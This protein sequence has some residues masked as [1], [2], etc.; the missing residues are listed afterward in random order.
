M[1]HKF[2]LRL[3]FIGAVLL[4]GT[5]IQLAKEHRPSILRP[6]LRLCAYVTNAG[7]GTVSVV[8][9]VRL[10]VTS[11]LP[12]GPSP[13]GI[14]A[15]PTRKEIWGVSTEGG[16]AWV[17]DAVRDQV[18]ARIPVGAAPFA[19][20]FSPEGNFAYVA[21]SGSAT[22]IAIDCRTRQVAG[23]A[24]TGRR[25][26]LARVTPD[27]RTLLVPNREDSTLGVY[28]AATLALVAT[29]PVAT[30]PEQVAVMPDSS[31]AFVSAFA[32]RASADEAAAGA[33]QISVVDLRRQTLLVN[34][35]V[36]GA[37]ADLILKPDGG[38][39][40]VTAPELHGLEVVNTWTTEV[41]ESMILGSAPSRGALTADAELLFV[42]DAAAGRV[43]PVRIGARQLLRPISVG[44]RPGVLRLAPGEDL[45]LVVNEDSN[46]LAVVRVRAQQTVP[47]SLIT[48]IPVGRHPRDLAIK[49]F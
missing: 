37:P 48:M 7:E 2:N 19:V 36:V 15:H 4:A 41:A 42:S 21:A 9:L 1:T 23:R 3:A 5:S 18:V 34:L 27:G 30:H 26:W 16:F 45:L 35:P 13:S 14:R 38:E 17:I 49:L 12:V 40:Y 44:Q 31:M 47:A 10:A 25:P 46:D 8:D 33:S 22:V 24:R 28:D 29:V 39:L 6:G 32:P 11:T 43:M 20:D